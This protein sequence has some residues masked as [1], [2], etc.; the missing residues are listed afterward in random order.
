[1]RVP[2]DVA[3]VGFDDRKSAV[4]MSP[5]L[6]TVAHPN[7]YLGVAAAGVLLKK[8]DGEPS[9]EGGWSRAIPAKLVMRESA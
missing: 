2:E 7:W 1:V 4:L 5:R 8:M 3:V 9:P 6:T